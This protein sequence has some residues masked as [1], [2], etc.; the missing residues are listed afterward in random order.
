MPAIS[1]IIPVYNSDKYLKQCLNS[2]FTQPWKNIEVITVNDA[3]T[4][5]SLDI[6][7]EYQK[8]Y[9]NLKIINNPVNIGIGA[10][11]NKALDIVEGKYILFVDSDDYI[12]YGTLENAFKCA[13]RTNSDLVRFDYDKFINKK[14]LEHNIL[15]KDTNLKYDYINTDDNYYIYKESMSICNKLYSKKLINNLR[16]EE[17]IHYENLPFFISTMFNAENIVYLKEN[18]Y[19]YRIKNKINPNIID[20]FEA[21]KLVDKNID[22]DE[23]INSIKIINCIKKINEIMLWKDL[24]KKEKQKLISYLFK[25]LE[26]EYGNIN[27]DYAYNL[28][29]EHDSLFKKNISKLKRN[30]KEEYQESNNISELKD[31]SLKIIKKI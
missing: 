8:T 5:S 16:F 9:H 24:S 7:L 29:K 30:I 20:I 11:R 27:D 15:D 22:N 28:L 19:R 3:S 31:M 26:L 13:Y 17:N 18:Y 21:C 14:V 23:N 25:I 10:S 2:I 12:E 6:L 4:D 1:I